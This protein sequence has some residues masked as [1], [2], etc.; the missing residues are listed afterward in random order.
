MGTGATRPMLQ[1]LFG[2]ASAEKKTPIFFSRS[3][4]R[5]AL[6]WGEQH[7]IALFKFD[8]RGTITPVTEMARKLVS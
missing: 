2:V 4:A 7:N 3:Y 5:T 1:Q 8:L 6:E